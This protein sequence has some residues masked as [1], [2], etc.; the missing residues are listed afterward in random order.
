MENNYT[1]ERTSG[2]NR[3]K[4]FFTIAISFL[5]GMTVAYILCQVASKV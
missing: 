3:I 1:D 5:V 4:N 2:S